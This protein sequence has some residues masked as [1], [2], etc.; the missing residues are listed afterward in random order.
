MATNQNDKVMKLD[1]KY[2]NYWGFKLDKACKHLGENVKFLGTFCVQG[3]Y[4]PVA[5]FYAPTPDKE[6]GHKHYPF[7]FMKG[8][9]MYVSAFDPEHFEP[10]RYQ[11]G[12]HCNHCKTVIYS[13]MRH[14]YRGCKCKESE[15]QIFVDGGRDYFK[16]SWGKEASFQ[17]VKIDFK[18][19]HI[20]ITED[21]RQKKDVKIDELADKLADEEDNS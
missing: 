9:T 14:D 5:M 1:H 11:T 13:T 6:K 10:E 18:T 3:N 7:L 2:H 19:G 15:K 20:E 12:T 17:H 16:F 21:A 4:E 8:K